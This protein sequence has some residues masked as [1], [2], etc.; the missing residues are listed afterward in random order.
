MR[1]GQIDL[2][3]QCPFSSTPTSK[4]LAGNSHATSI[5]LKQPYLSNPKFPNSSSELSSVVSALAVS[6]DNQVRELTTDSLS[7]QWASALLQD[8]YDFIMSYHQTHRST[9]PIPIPQFRFVV[10]GLAM[11]NVP[12]SEPEEKEV[13]LVEELIQSDGPWRKYINNNSSRPC[14][15]SDNKNLRRSQ[16]LAF[17]QHVQYWRMDGLVFI[18]DFQVG[19]DTLLTDPQIITHPWWKLFSKGNVQHTH[20]NF[21]QDH[22]CNIFCKFFEVPTSYVQ[23]DQLEGVSTQSG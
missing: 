3:G 19:G 2:I 12:G 9:C 23:N 8:V 13:F 1:E 20:N 4:S 14:S 18:S 22:E 5:A 10:S 6:S 7:I 11:T 17:C 21:K 16:F 15:F